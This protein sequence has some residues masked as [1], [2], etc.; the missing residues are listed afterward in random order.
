MNAADRPPALLAGAAPPL[1]SLALAVLD[2]PGDAGGGVEAGWLREQAA[3]AGGATFADWRRAPPDE[4]ARLHALGRALGLGPVELVA[5]ALAAAVEADPLAG[6]VL[7]WLQA[8]AGGARPGVGLLLTLA[9]ALGLPDAMASLVDGPARRAGLLVADDEGRP[10]PEQALRMPLPTVLALRGE[11]GGWPGVR[12]GDAPPGV[13]PSLRRAAAAQAAALRHDAPAQDA[14]QALA[15]R[16]GHPREA[17]IAAALVAAALDRVPAYVEGEP[18]PGLAPW[19]WLRGALP[20][21]CGELAPGETRRL[22]ALRGYRGALLVATGLDGSFEREG[23]P[24]PSWRVPLPPPAE[25]AALWR[26]HLPARRRRARRPR[27][28]PR[29]GAHRRSSRARRATQARL[30]ATGLPASGT[31]AS[32]RGTAPAGELG[33]LAQ[34]LP[35]DVPDDALVMPPALRGDARRAVPALRAARGAGRRRSARRR[36]RATAPACARCSSALRAPA[37]RWR[38]H[39]LASRLGLPLYRVDLAAMASKWIGE[40]EKNLAQLFARAEH[41]EVVLLFDEAD[42]LFGRRTE[43]KDAND[44]FANAQTNYLLQRIEASTASRC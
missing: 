19:L 37:R 30:P 44:R 41:A 24:V 8:P 35:D 6:R 15:V 39:W 27:A 31:C 21:L 5:A 18:P 12:L 10:L 33:A 2:D 9:A 4:D 1:R 26:A 32:P 20:V 34:L 25:R 16:S 13:P 7:A 3:Q 36:G 29:A 17:R 38:R 22:P 23:D 11:G 14:V 40:T 42:S 28:P 43:V